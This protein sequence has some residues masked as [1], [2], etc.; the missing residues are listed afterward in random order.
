MAWLLLIIVL[1]LILFYCC[2]LYEA[3]DVSS[4]KRGP[5]PF[6]LSSSRLYTVT[7]VFPLLYL[8]HAVHILSGD[9]L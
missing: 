7:S 8:K 2:K 5:D 3:Y 9:F 6:S 4:V 1:L